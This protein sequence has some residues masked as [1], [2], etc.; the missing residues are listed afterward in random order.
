MRGPTRQG[1]TLIELLVVIAIIAILAAILFPV[2]AQA[3]EKARSASCQSNLKQIGLAAMMY[4]QDYDEIHLP[5][6]TQGG[7]GYTGGGYRNWWMG[8]CQPYVKNLKLFECPSNPYNWRGYAQWGGGGQGPYAACVNYADSYIRF[9]GGYGMNWTAFNTQN[10]GGTGG[11]YGPGDRG[12][13]GNWTKMARISSPAETIFVMD[14]NC[15]VVGRLPCWPNANSTAPTVGQC[16]DPEPTSGRG[17]CG[18]ANQA[19]MGFLR[20]N[21]GGN[22]LFDDGHVKWMRTSYNYR[23]GDPFYLWRTTK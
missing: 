11:C 2:F 10:A 5:M 16:F 7:P 4:G 12:D 6:W 22:I 14:S 1:F 18:C 20:H 21:G 13:L 23:A 17:W 8:L 3:R 9:W 15:V 19:A